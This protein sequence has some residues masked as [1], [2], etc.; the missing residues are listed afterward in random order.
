M[1]PQPYDEWSILVPIAF[2][3][4]TPVPA[5]TI[6]AIETAML[7]IAGGFTRDGTVTGVWRDPEDGTVYRDATTRY[8]IAT[9]HADMWRIAR[10][11]AKLTDQRTVYIARTAD[12]VE[13]V[14][15]DM[16]AA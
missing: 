3:D 10:M 11:V 4:G 9:D 12:R 6:A 13:F 5:D 14:A 16:I 1:T 15:Q 7:D 2:N 8:L